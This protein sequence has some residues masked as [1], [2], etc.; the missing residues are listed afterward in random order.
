MKR[1]YHAM[2]CSRSFIGMSPTVYTVTGGSTIASFVAC[3]AGGIGASWRPD[4]LG[5]G[6]GDGE[7]GA[8][9]TEGGW[10]GG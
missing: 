1:V 10:S 2:H 3:S 6:V 8:G 9:G 5:D 4:R 7:R